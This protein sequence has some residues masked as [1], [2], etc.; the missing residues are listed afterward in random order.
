MKKLISLM[1]LSLISGMAFAECTVGVCSNVE[2]DRVYATVGNTVYVGTTGDE[3]NLGCG[4]VADVYGKLDMTNPSA[5]AVYS[6]ILAAQMAKKK[7]IMKVDE[8]VAGCPISY[9]VVQ[10][11]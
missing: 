10:S 2:V 1:G 8:N 3:R 11:D 4:A 6:A 7:I 9:V 5:D